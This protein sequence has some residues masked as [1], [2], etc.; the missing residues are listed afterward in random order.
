MFEQPKTGQDLMTSQ[1]I[2]DIWRHLKVCSPDNDFMDI[3][4]TKV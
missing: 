3:K 4:G 1:Q 2:T